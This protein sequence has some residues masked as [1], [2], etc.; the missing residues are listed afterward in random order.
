MSNFQGL[1]IHKYLEN[2]IINHNIFLS[3]TGLCEFYFINIKCIH[4]K[5]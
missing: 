5:L 3:K 2:I 4:I 1:T